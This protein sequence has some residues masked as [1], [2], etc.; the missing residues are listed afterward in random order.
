MA[1][2]ESMPVLVKAMD[3][4]PVMTSAVPHS[5]FFMPRVD[6]KG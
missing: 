4:D 1:I 6:T 2:R 5:T 3:F